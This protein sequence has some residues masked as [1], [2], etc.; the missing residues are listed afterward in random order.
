MHQV[1]KHSGEFTAT[2]R[3]ASLK[4][5][6][7]GQLT[8]SEASISQAEAQNAIQIPGIRTQPLGIGRSVQSVQPG[9]SGTHSCSQRR[10][11]HSHINSAPE[12]FEIEPNFNPHYPHLTPQPTTHTHYRARLEGL[13]RP[14]QSL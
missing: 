9:P 6:P 7:K 1:H 2:Q 4:V 11:N 14:H 12:E 13:P 3:P 5:R 8:Q 10:E